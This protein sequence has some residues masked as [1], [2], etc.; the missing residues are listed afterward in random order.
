VLKLTE[1][2]V[3]S[4]PILASRNSRSAAAGRSAPAAALSG[5]LRVESLTECCQCQI[6]MAGTLAGSFSRKARKGRNP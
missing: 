2:L 6:Q 4:S 1:P 3:F 5:R